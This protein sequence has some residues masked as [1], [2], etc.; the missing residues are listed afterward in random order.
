MSCVFFFF[1]FLFPVVGCI[2]VCGIISLGLY[3]LSLN[4]I[5]FPSEV[6][7]G[8]QCDRR[9]YFL[10]YSKINMCNIYTSMTVMQ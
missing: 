3:G 8:T 5:F 6:H 9:V 2:L 4:V 7:P 1:C 10:S